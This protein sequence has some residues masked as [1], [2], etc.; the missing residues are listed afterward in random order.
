M[1]PSSALMSS[2]MPVRSMVVHR[3]IPATTVTIPRPTESRKAILKT[4]Q[5]LTLA[6]TS[7]ARRAFAFGAGRT[8]P[9]PS[10]FLFLPSGLLTPIAGL[11]LSLLLTLLHRSYQPYLYH[12]DYVR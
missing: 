5:A 1:V 10:T 4:D 9:L 2:K 7:F 8:R 6:M 11:E 3:K 12:P